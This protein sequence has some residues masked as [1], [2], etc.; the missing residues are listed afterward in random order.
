MEST[1]RPQFENKVGVKQHTFV[2]RPEDMERQGNVI[3]SN[4]CEQH[5]VLTIL[6]SECAGRLVYVCLFKQ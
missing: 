3:L 2:F 6:F 1:Y 5:T 4:F